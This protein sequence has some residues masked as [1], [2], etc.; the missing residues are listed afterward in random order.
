MGAKYDYF[1]IILA[2]VIFVYYAPTPWQM[3]RF[4]EI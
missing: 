1:K 3:E 2:T 4:T